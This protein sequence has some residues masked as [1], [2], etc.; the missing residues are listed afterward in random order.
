MNR[1]FDDARYYFGRG[2]KHATAGVSQ[3]LRPVVSRVR[4]ALGWEPKPEPKRLER[5][6]M[7]LRE[8][9]SRAEGESKRMLRDARERVREY[10]AKV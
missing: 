2:L 7:E 6:Q 4:R 1:H 5:V 10:R 9:E 3:E 8:F